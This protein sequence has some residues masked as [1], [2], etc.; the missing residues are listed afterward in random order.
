MLLAAAQTPAENHTCHQG[1]SL[2]AKVLMT[3]VATRDANKMT[4][5]WRE[6]RR[7]RYHGGLAILE[8]T[9]R[10]SPIP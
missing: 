6:S 3:S 9:G 10:F 2:H 5:S 8:L 7:C 1:V 4:S